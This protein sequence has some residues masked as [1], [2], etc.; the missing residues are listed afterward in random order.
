[1]AIPCIHLLM[2][3]AGSSENWFVLSMNPLLDIQP[4]PAISGVCAR[5]HPTVALRTVSFY[6]KWR[7]VL[8]PTFPHY[9]IGRGITTPAPNPLSF[10]WSQVL[11]FSSARNYMPDYFLKGSLLWLS[12]F[13][14]LN[15]GQIFEMFPTPVWFSI[16]AHLSMLPALFREGRSLVVDHCIDSFS[17]PRVCLVNWLPYFSNFP[18]MSYY[19]CL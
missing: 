14:F 13:L 19:V 11:P 4:F 2:F 7:N 18:L 16:D 15:E 6:P 10:A 9:L 12:W 1:M 3:E 5:L 17:F 8:A